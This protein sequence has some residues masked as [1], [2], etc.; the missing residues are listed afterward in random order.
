MTEI[1]NK[2]KKE[3]LMS[4][5]H[6]LKSATY[7]PIYYSDYKFYNTNSENFGLNC[8]AYAMQFKYNF[9][10]LRKKYPKIELIYEPGFLSIDGA[11]DTGN[12]DLLIH[13]FTEDCKILGLECIRSSVN[14]SISNNEYKIAVFLSMNPC[15]FTSVKDFHFIRQNA[16]LSWS[17]M[18]GYCG[19][20]QQKEYPRSSRYDLVEIFK[21]KKQTR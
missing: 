3:I 17:E 12:P 19:E 14:D 1:N 11:R 13:Y 7:P 9:K 8:Y 21:V 10:A 5:K 2:I 6:S 18:T 15:Y 20:V 4:L 16:D